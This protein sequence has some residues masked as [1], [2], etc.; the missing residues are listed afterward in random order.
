VTGHLYNTYTKNKDTIGLKETMDMM[1]LKRICCRATIMGY[2]EIDDMN[3]VEP[4]NN[5]GEK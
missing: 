2:V 3:F 4:K 5:L 1:K